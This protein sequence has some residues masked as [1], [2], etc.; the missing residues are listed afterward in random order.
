VTNSSGGAVTLVLTNGTTITTN[1]GPNITIQ[2]PVTVRVKAV[3][4]SGSPINGARVYLEAGAGGPLSQGTSIMNTTTSASGIVENTAF[5]Y[6]A[7]QLLQNSR[8]RKGTGSPAYVSAVIS[9]TIGSTG[10]D[11]TITMISD[12]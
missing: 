10:F 3:D 6:S 12:D 4:A 5:N 8:V 9:G 7:D 1:T 11:V 2:Q